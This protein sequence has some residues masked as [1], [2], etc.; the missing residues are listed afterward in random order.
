MSDFKLLTQREIIDILIGDTIIFEKETQQFRLPY[1]S[2]PILCAI[3]TRFGLEQSYTWGGGMSRWQYLKELLDYLDNKGS[4]GDFIK[5]LLDFSNFQ[6]VLKDV[7]DRKDIQDYYKD[8]VKSAI[9]AINS[10]LYYSGKELLFINSNFIVA[11]IGEAIIV[12][13]DKISNISVEYIKGLVNRVE[14]DM[15]SQQ[16]DSVVTK[17]RTLI[18]EVII[19]VLEQKE[20]PVPTSGNLLELYKSCKIALGMKQDRS[21]DKR[22]LEMLSGLEKIIN[23]IS[24]MRNINSDAHGVGVA[25]IDI[26]EREAKLIINATITMCEYILDVYESHK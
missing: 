1:L 3:S 20:I 19:Y 17:S 5:Y 2:G 11:D 7:K 4:V 14:E 26:K 25:R 15:R 8:I 24:G 22:I 12:P 6:D 10:H 16:Y 23:A 9:T 18:E 21:W 13:T